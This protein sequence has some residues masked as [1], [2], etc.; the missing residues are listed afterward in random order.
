MMMVVSDSGKE[1]GP[2]RPAAVAGAFYPANAG[3][4]QAMI[5]RQM[6]HARRLVSSLAPRL[7]QGAP[8]AVIVPH[9]GYVYSGSV[10]ALAYALLER[11]PHS[12][13]RAAQSPPSEP[14]ASLIVRDWYAILS[15]RIGPDG[16]CPDCGAVVPG[17][18]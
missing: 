14:P 15:D 1:A 3:E 12:A 13:R 6:N 5:D 2:V 7:P 17:H 11:T 16:C 10:A 9:A 4:L 18:W 8:K